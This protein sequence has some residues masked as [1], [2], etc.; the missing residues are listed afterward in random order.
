MSHRMEKEAGGTG[1]LTRDHFHFLSNWIIKNTSGE[2][3]VTSSGWGN[4]GKA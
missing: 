1:K 2:L 4:G 3:K